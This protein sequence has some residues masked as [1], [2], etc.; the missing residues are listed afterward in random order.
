MGWVIWSV[1]LGGV[2]MIWASRHWEI[3]RAKREQIPLTSQSYPG[4]PAQAPMVSVLIAAKDEE[5]NIRTALETF[6][7]QD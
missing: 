6:L 3:S 7:A 1:L 4:P 5:A 2:A